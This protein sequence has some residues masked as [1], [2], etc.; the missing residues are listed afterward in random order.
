V[1]QLQSHIWMRKGSLIYEELRKYFPIYEEAVSHIWLCNCSISNFLIHEENFIFFFISA[2]G[3]AFLSTLFLL[4]VGPA[5]RGRRSSIVGVGSRLKNSTFF[6]AV[7]WNFLSVYSF[8]A[9]DRPLTVSQ[10]LLGYPFF[11]WNCILGHFQHMNG[12]T[13]MNINDVFFV[14]GVPDR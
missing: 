5:G 6:Y 11:I 7:L 2:V 13:L 14:K 1:E 3:W 8:N 9:S 4:P 12:I 10:L